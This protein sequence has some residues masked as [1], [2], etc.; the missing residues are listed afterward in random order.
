M[1]AFS[2]F[3]P[4]YTNEL[5]YGQGDPTRMNDSLIYCVDT[6][7]ASGQDNATP[8]TRVVLCGQSKRDAIHNLILSVLMCCGC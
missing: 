7:E 6:E 8:T 1:L 5:D 2:L 4:L 3:S